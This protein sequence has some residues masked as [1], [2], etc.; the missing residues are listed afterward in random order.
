[1]LYCDLTG[2]GWDEVE[3]PKTDMW[4]MWVVTTH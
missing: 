2:A 1:M 3:D 4:V